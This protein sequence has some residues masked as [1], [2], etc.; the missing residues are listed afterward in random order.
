M[1]R[2]ALAITGSIIGS[3]FGPVGAQ[4]GYFVGDQVGAY[5]EGPTN[6]PGP[7]LGDA[8]IQTSRDGVR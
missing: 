4:V 5:I 1:A 2:Q 6:I 3:N 7:S 8:S